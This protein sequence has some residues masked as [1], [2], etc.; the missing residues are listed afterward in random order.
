MSARMGLYVELCMRLDHANA[1][2]LI[3]ARDAEVIAQFEGYP[4]ELAALRGALSAIRTT[5]QHGTLDD[6]RREVA[7]YY[8][9]ERTAYAEQGEK[10]TATAATSTPQPKPVYVFNRRSVNRSTKHVESTDRAGRTLC[11]FEASLPMDAARATSLPL[12]GSCRRHG[13]DAR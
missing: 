12:C 6:V 4:G 8:A 7:E 13:G 2:Q 1:Q 10:D 11:G 9:D 3:N 5:A